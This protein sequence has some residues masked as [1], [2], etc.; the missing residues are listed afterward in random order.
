MVSL[1]VSLSSSV[2]LQSCFSLTEVSAVTAVN[3]ALEDDD[4]EQSY[5]LLRL[6]DLG[7]AYTIPE[8]AQTYHEQLQEIRNE[9]LEEGKYSSC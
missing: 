3:I 2:L 9:K 8:C 1:D 4:W 6:P 5:K 7:L